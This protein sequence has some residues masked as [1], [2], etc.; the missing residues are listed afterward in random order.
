ME[1]RMSAWDTRRQFGQVL[2]DVVRDGSTVIVESRGEEV[3]AIVPVRVYESIQRNREM[4]HRQLREIS[5]SVNMDEDE[6]MRLAL[7]TV[8]EVRAERKSVPA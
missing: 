4:L 6:A 2:K 1:K 5:E 3:A 8:A 7:E